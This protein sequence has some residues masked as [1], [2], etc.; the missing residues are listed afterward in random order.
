MLSLLVVH[1]SSHS[2]G[3]MHRQ[4]RQQSHEQLR[5]QQSQATPILKQ[6]TGRD[7]DVIADTEEPFERSWLYV[8]RQPQ[9][10]SSWNTAGEVLMDLMQCWM[11][12][13]SFSVDEQAHGSPASGVAYLRA[14]DP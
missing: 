5:Q 2:I 14:L 8:R 6:Q 11:L 10:H 13:S 9:M 3:S 12:A 7:G 4:L 1:L